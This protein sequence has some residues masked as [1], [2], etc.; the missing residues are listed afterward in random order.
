MFENFGEK[1]DMEN[2]EN[3]LPL[4][5]G[6]A[7]EIE[8]DDKYVEAIGGAR[9]FKELFRVIKEIGQIRGSREKP[10]D[11]FEIKRIIYETYGAFFLEDSY[12][13][14]EEPLAKITGSL[15]LRNKVR[16]L[17]EAEKV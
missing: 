17:L 10:Y 9:N 11:Y 15:G 2:P 4:G 6:K 1:I 7:Y 12:P 8:K 14:F 3:D 16:E 13:A 5:R